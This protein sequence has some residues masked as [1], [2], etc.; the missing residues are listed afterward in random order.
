ME[1]VDGPSLRALIDQHKMSFPISAA[2]AILRGILN[3]LTAAHAGGL[4]HRDLKPA[5]ILL[6]QPPDDLAKIGE[7]AVRVTDFGLGHVGGDTTQ[8]IM[9]SGSLETEEGRSIAGTLAYMSPEQ[10]TG[11]AIDGRSDLFACGIILFEMLTGERPAGSELPSSLRHESPAY[12]DDVF[13]RCYAR[14]DRRFPSVHEV[15]AALSPEARPVRPSPPQGF[16]AI[17]R[18]PG[19]TQIVAADDQYCIQCG[20]QIS[21]SVP[22]CPAC[23]GFVHPKDQFCIFCGKDLRVLTA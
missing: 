21:A 8:S 9:Q 3:A 7:H 2:T 1:F 4:V 10:K 22:R 23:F 6:H 5:N 17:R 18:C 14:L 15:L 16:G 19:C 12:L 20:R 13:Q 11:G